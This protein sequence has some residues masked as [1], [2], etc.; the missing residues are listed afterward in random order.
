MVSYPRRNQVQIEILNDHQ[1]LT[2]FRSAQNLN[3]RQARWSLYLSHFDFGLIHRPGRHS[4][5]PDALSRW[6][7][8]K[9]GEEDN[10]NQM[11]LQP[12]MF[13]VDATGAQLING[14]ADKFLDRVRDCT[15]RD[16][17]V[18]KALKELGT[19]GNL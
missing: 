19:S 4:A 8:H 6:V 2:Y 7:D 15:D 18:V 3:R 9:Q 14:E 1:N 12:D 11:L 10:Q 16:E 13:H 17:K 5:K